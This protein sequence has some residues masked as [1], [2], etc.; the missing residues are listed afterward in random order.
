MPAENHDEDDQP[1]TQDPRSYDARAQRGDGAPEGG[2][3]PDGSKESKDAKPRKK[4]LAQRPVTLAVIVLGVIVLLVLIVLFW[5]HARHFESTDDAFIDTHIVLVAPRVSGRV[6]KVLVEDNQRVAAGQPLIEVD[7]RTYQ[8]TLDQGEGSLAQANAQIAQAQAA[9]VQN[10]AQVKVSEANVRQTQ[11]S[12]VSSQAQANFAA[13]DLARYTTLKSINPTAVAQ[14]Q[15]DQATSSFAS[16]NAQ[17]E[18]ALRQID[19]SRAQVA[20]TASQRATAVA[21]VAAGQAQAQSA[22]ATIANAQLDL[23][24]T[25]V[26]APEA[27]TIA[28]RTVALGN[29]LNPGAEI[30]AIVPLRIWVTAN[31]KETQLDHMRAGQSVDLHVDACPRARITGHVDSIQRGSGQAFGILPPQ[32]AT[33]NFVKVVQRVPVK[34]LLDGAPA[35]CPLGPGLSV[36]PKVRVN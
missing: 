8:A 16:M 25:V 30:M 33:G 11:A 17:H 35:D 23:G 32:N 7:P 29:Y 9:L 1:K 4:G 10:D 15:L 27:G 31:F 2:G 26:H 6:S 3:E 19:A 5:L 12:A 36:E 18:A 13:S 34:I 28:Q 24:F 20:A 22:R 21:Q 14:Q